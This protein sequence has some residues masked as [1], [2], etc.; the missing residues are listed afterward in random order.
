[1][2]DPHDDISP[3]TLREEPYSY[4]VILLTVQLRLASLCLVKGAQLISGPPYTQTIHLSDKPRRVV[5]FP[6]PRLTP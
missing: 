3:Y 1:M 4:G 2:G 6:R 5:Y